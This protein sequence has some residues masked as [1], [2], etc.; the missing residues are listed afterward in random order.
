MCVAAQLFLCAPFTFILSLKAPQTKDVRDILACSFSA[1]TDICWYC[2]SRAEIELIP[3]VSW[4]PPGPSQ[5]G[6]HQYMSPRGGIG[7]ERDKCQSRWNEGTTDELRASRSSFHFLYDAAS[8]L[9]PLPSFPRARDCATDRLDS[10][11]RVSSLAR[12]FVIRPA[13]F[14]SCQL[15]PAEGGSL[16]FIWA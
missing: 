9:L 11:S 13:C 12:R 8:T 14:M 6:R 5:C 15:P 16:I 3:S 4:G 10:T 7:T 1:G 2:A